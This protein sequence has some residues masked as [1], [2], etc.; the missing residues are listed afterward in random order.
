MKVLYVCH[1]SMIGGGTISALDVVSS[2]VALGYD[3]D[4]C[5][6]SMNETLNTQIVNLGATPKSCPNICLL[7]YYSGST[8]HL[9]TFISYLV[10]LKN[11]RKWKEYLR[12]RQ[13]DL[14]CFNS[15]TQLP[16]AK[17][18]HNAGIRNI[19]FIR[20]TKNAKKHFFLEYIQ[21]SY[22][23]YVDYYSYLSDY[24]F[25]TW[26]FTDK[27]Y[28]VPDTLRI[29]KMAEC[30]NLYK[31]SF[32]SHC[33]LSILFLGGF[34]KIKGGLTLLKALSLEND[35]KIE[36]K[37]LGVDDSILNSRKAKIFKH[38]KNSNVAY[39]IACK[40]FFEIIKKQ[41][42]ITVRIMP[43]QVDLSCYFQD[44]D[45]IVFPATEMHQARP[46]YEAGYYHKPVI[47]SDYPCYAEYIKDFYNGRVFASGDYLALHVLLHEFAVDKGLCEYM[48]N[49]NYDYYVKYHE[50]D[51]VQKKLKLLLDDCFS[52]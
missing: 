48:G 52:K 5:F 47:V 29:P 19:C 31:K 34:S 2:L 8:S 24:D 44:C 26:N 36:C 21:N 1:C 23:K 3:V 40:S 15:V 39:H 27:K 17:I 28:I 37:I 32:D 33:D 38:I 50:Y 4:V 30:S 12:Y 6:P 20:E 14:I 13:Y 35:A 42:N 10:S 43:P 22:S 46:I 16:L 41:S 11:Q 9:K 18:V 7:S 45:V 49:N 25:R 51:T